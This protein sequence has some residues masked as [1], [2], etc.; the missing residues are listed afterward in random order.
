MAW[1]PQ[2]HGVIERVHREIHKNLG[3]ALESMAAV[4]EKDWPRFVCQA[5]MVWRQ[6]DLFGS[7]ISP[8]SMTH[9]WYPTSPLATTLE[10][11]R[12]IPKGLPHSTFVRGIIAASSLLCREYDQAKQEASDI[13]ALHRAPDL[14]PRAF[15]A[16]DHVF[17]DRQDIGVGHKMRSRGQGPWRVR[18]VNPEGTAV[19]LEDPSTRR[20]ILDQ[21]TGLPDQISTRRLMKFVA[22]VSETPEG[23]DA[24]LLQLEVGDVVAYSTGSEILLAKVLILN[25]GVTVFGRL[26]EVPTSHRERGLSEKPWL[27]S[28]DETELGWGVLIL[29]VDLKADHTLEP[30][31][32]NKLVK[33]S[34]GGTDQSLYE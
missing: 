27:P 14:R 6:K 17:L 19:E 11:I 15:V 34:G 28:G 25:V 23:P 1:A 18:F 3:R 30:S 13:E 31:S 4:Q 7:G 16:G 10:S 20:P 2:G 8:Y 29:K 22:P 5:V 26:L 21:L 24:D 32:M 33:L 12:E 9:G